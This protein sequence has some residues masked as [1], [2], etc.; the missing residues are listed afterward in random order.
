MWPTFSG[1]RFVEHKHVQEAASGAMVESIGWL[2]R[3]ESF[4]RRMRGT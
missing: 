4:H 2:L 3:G 1:D